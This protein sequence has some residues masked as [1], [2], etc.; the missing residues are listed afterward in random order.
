VSFMV[1]GGALR[2]FDIENMAACTRLRVGGS[3]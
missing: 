1:D 2:F 3:F